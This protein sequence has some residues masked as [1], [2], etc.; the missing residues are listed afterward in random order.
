MTVLSD[1][2]VVAA[3]LAGAA[4]CAD[5]RDD[6]PCQFP[7]TVGVEHC[8]GHV[9]HLLFPR[10][11]NTS[12]GQATPSV[13]MHQALRELRG[14]LAKQIE[15]ALAMNASAVDRSANAARATAVVDDLVAALPA[16]QR[17]ME[18][19]LGAALVGDPAA[20][21]RDE[22]LLCYPGVQAVMAHRVAHALWL[23]DVPLIPRLM[24]EI[25]HAK[26]GI[27]I[28]PGAVIGDA[29]FIDHGTGVVIGETTII[30]REVRLYQGVTLGA[31]SVTNSPDPGAA[32]RK[33][34]AKRHPTLGDNVVV[35]A[36][37]TILG[38]NTVI[39]NG[40]TVGGNAWV[41][42]SVAAGSTVMGVHGGR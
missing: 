31:L 16:L 26:T 4:A 27:D 22:I 40:A 38:G 37:A 10:L 36:G 25:A 41:T 39:G 21:N 3:L 29:F 30:G 5:Q 8:L 33:R 23:A 18:L 19:D 1:D 15:I 2:H 35:Y 14:G 11:A 12:Q 9:R 24:A 42:S 7:S 6:V 28:H 32:P 17:R 34:G 20:T 13:T